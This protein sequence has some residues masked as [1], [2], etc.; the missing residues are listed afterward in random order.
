MLALVNF[1]G[2]AAEEAMKGDYAQALNDD[3]VTPGGLAGKMPDIVMQVNEGAT[4]IQKDMGWAS[5]A[6]SLLAWKGATFQA[7][8]DK[9][10]VGKPAGAGGS[11]TPLPTS[12][13]DALDATVPSA[14]GLDSVKENT[15]KS[16]YKSLSGSYLKDNTAQE[17]FDNLMAVAAVYSGQIGM[18]KLTLGQVL[19]SVDK[20]MAN[21]LGVPDQGLLAAKI[22]EFLATPGGKKYADSFTP[23]ASKVSQ[24][25]GK[26]QEELELAEF[27]KNHK[28][29]VYPGPGA[30]DPSLQAKDFV[31][32]NVAQS[33][34]NQVALDAKL[35]KTP[36]KAQMDAMVWYTG[37]GASAMN[38]YLRHGNGSTKVAVSAKHV[39]DAMTP[40]DKPALLLRRTGWEF[41]P[42]QYRSYEGMQSLIN[43][44]FHDAA[45]NS[46]TVA[47]QPGHYGGGLPVKLEIEAPVGTRAYHA[48]HFSQF[49]SENEVILGSNQTFKV[50]GVKKM[51][52]GKVVVRVRVVT[53]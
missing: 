27:K 46:T 16:A 31:K 39:E 2:T 19:A 35:G 14:S 18:P 49:A 15:L 5:D 43:G 8:I 45:F 1:D 24:L 33:Y 50:V 28:H 34:A 32:H 51:A 53:P 10:L 40:L 7:L 47:G 36:T 12:V 3:L 26:V 17:N 4:K 6:P 13:K 37:S 20:T 29:P 41:V 48:Q 11:A 44:T 38:E 42:K 21:D 22:Q 9:E 25:T 23:N 30:F 52:D